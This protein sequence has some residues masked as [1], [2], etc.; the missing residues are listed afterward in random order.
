MLQTYVIR[1]MSGMKNR[2]TFN[3]QPMFENSPFFELLPMGDA[4]N[5]KTLQLM[6]IIVDIQ[7][8]NEYSYILQTYGM[9]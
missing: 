2:P 7:G 3:N 9:L 5:N 6:L 4:N 8:V 1:Y